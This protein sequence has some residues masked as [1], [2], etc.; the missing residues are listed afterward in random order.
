[1]AYPGLLLSSYL[2]F[3][4]LLHLLRFLFYPLPGVLRLLF[5]PLRRLLYLLSYLLL[6]LLLPLLYLLLYLLLHSPS[7]RC[8]A[9]HREQSSRKEDSE[10]SPHASPSLRVDLPPEPPRGAPPPNTSD[11]STVR[12]VGLPEIPSRAR[13]AY[14]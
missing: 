10:S 8:Y 11:Q 3:Y 5:Y 6:Y 14:S 12:G 9:E 7:A 2:L 13:R 1:M 4:L